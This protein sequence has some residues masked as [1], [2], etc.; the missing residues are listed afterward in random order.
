[1]YGEH[2]RGKIISFSFYRSAYLCMS[3][4]I[5]CIMYASYNYF[6]Y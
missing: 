4:F 2:E 6:I 5:Y 1:M 3:L